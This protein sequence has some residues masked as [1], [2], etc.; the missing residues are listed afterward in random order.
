MREALILFYF[1]IFKLSPR[2]MGT[3]FKEE[4]RQPGNQSFRGQLP[5]EWG[6]S[7]LFHIKKWS[8]ELKY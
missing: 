4:Y 1:V 6:R 3:I 8:K 2:I 7:K 5:G